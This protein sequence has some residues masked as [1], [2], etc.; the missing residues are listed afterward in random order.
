[1]FQPFYCLGLKRKYEY[2]VFMGS[3]SRTI[4]L[5]SI[6]GVMNCAPS[7]RFFL[8]LF[9]FLEHI[10]C[11]PRPLKY[12]IVY[13]QRYSVAAAAERFFVFAL[14]VYTRRIA[15]YVHRTIIYYYLYYTLLRRRY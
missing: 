14:I 10:F 11:T 8:I 1:M 9:L 12:C 6:L 7:K 5:K 13:R 4:I 3:S 2:S 15:H